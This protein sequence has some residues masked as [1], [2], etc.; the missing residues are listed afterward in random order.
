[1]IA[2]FHNDFLTTRNGDLRSVSQNVYCAVCAVFRGARTF[3]ETAQIVNDFLKEQPK[4]LFLGL[5]DIGYADE[6]NIDEICSWN[7]VYASLTW[8]G[9]NELAGGCA[10][11]GGLTDR[12]RAIVRRLADENILLDC[13][14]L[15][16]ES[17]CEALELG[18]LPVDSHTCMNAVWGHPRNLEDWQVKEIVARDGLVG[19]TFVEKFLC[20]GRATAENIFRHTDYAV[21]KF[22]IDGFCFGTD[23]YGADRFPEGMEEYGGEELLRECFIK[24]GYSVNDVSKLFV[25]NLQNLLSKKVL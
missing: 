6:A 14:H 9:R 7:P 5:E 23:F 4:N 18:A 12:G 22:G 1:M 3:A 25:Q 17:F 13:A 24:H 2:D 11:E 21:Q 16:R 8:N 15:N 10:A 19:I 20:A